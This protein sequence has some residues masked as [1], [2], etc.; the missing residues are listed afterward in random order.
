[1][2]YLFSLIGE[3]TI[4]RAVWNDTWNG[5]RLTF[6]FAF[7]QTTKIEEKCQDKMSLN[8]LNF[9]LFLDGLRM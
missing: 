8:Y 9:A 5:C 4:N 7:W 3:T 2:L 6:L 1:M